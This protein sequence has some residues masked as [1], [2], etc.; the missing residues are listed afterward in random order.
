MNQEPKKPIQP[1][2]FDQT[3]EDL[4]LFSNTC[5]RVKASPYRPKPYH[6]Q[7]SLIDMRPQFKAADRPA[8]QEPEQQKGL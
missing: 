5:P 3:H 4:P 6:R 2:F 8:T 7:Y 1:G